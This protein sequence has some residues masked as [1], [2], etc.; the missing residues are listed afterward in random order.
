MKKNQKLKIKKYLKIIDEIE[1]TRSKNNVNW[2][3]I[4]RLSIKNSPDE[5]MK[6]MKKIDSKDSKISNLFKKLS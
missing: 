6:I 3:D 1:K 5:T 4:L 2:M